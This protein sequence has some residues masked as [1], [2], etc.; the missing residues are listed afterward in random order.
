MII[1]FNLIISLIYFIK[2]IP[3]QNEK[4]NPRYPS[5]ITITHKLLG[6]E[7]PAFILDPDKLDYYIKRRNKRKIRF[8]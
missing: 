6:M 7:E 4:V 1:N 5:T 8:I 2:T 3:R